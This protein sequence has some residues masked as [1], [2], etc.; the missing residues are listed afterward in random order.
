MRNN[1]SIYI[2]NRTKFL[3]SIFFNFKKN[4][5]YQD[6]KFKNIEFLNCDSENDDLYIP[7][8]Q[9]LIHFKCSNNKLTSN[10]FYNKKKF[11]LNFDC[12]Y[13]QISNNDSDLYC[14]KIKNLE[15][16]L[17]QSFEINNQIRIS[18]KDQENIDLEYIL[19]PKNRL[20]WKKEENLNINDQ[21]IS[22]FKKAIIFFPSHSLIVKLKRRSSKRDEYKL[23]KIYF[24]N[25]N[26][27]KY[28]KKWEN[29]N[30][31]IFVLLL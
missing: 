21:M 22:S 3:F 9:D 11:T 27:N 1:Y 16:L 10:Y 4:M 26:N 30:D 18:K 31:F 5:K 15:N 17:I 23:K 19:I 2:S 20:F 13:N 8:I 29:V 28:F 25:E 6:I 14:I 12:P 7:K 24:K